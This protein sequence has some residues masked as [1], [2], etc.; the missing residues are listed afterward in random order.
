[1]RTL[2]LALALALPA[3]AQDH[4]FSR[5]ETVVSGSTKTTR[6]GFSTRTGTGNVG[7]IYLG[8]PKGLRCLYDLGSPTDTMR[9]SYLYNASN[10][11]FTSSS[12]P[13]MASGSGDPLYPLSAVIY[14]TAPTLDAV[15]RYLLAISDGTSNNRFLVYRNANVIYNYVS[16]GGASG[17]AS[18][19]GTLNA[20]R[21]HCIIAVWTSAS[22]RAIYVDTNPTGATNSTTC[23]TTSID[24]IHFGTNEAASGA[25]WNGRIGHS[26]LLPVALSAA[27]RTAIF[28]GADPVIAAGF[29]YNSLTRTSDTARGGV[30]K[31]D[32]DAGA[33]A[34]VNGYNL[35]NANATVETQLYVVRDLSG[36]R[37]HQKA[38]YAAPLYSTSV[39]NGQGG[40]VYS[41]ASTQWLTSTTTPITAPPFQFYSVAQSNDVT[42]RYATVALTDVDGVV[43]SWELWFNGTVG[44]DPISMNAQAGGSY[45]T[46][47]TS[48]GYSAST[49]YLMWGLETSSTS[50]AAEKNGGS[51]GTDSTSRSPAGIDCVTLGAQAAGLFVYRPLDGELYHV[52]ILDHASTID[53]PRIE[54]FYSTPYALGY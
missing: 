48:T 43:D 2:A 49:D 41:Y 36:G 20:T 40:G 39:G 23:N 47:S 30:W 33:D 14:F 15:D 24:R 46:A 21:W 29:T 19:S 6:F 1:M 26:C 4:T 12:V 16:G 31:F 11:K 13:C 52:M 10:A 28:E 32:N 27:Q 17:Y 53:Q 18:L 37:Y 54:R 51:Q 9:G 3:V 25:W 45:G 5:T 8:F 35:T 50:R 38:N 7:G 44:G 34:S 22:S 42:G